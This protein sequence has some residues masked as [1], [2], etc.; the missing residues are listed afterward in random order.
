M[1]LWDTIY[2]ARGMP[3]SRYN[4]DNE[5]IIRK[6]SHTED[7]LNSTKDILAHFIVSLST[8]DQSLLVQE[9]MLSCLKDLEAVKAYIACSIT[10][11]RSMKHISLLHDS[12]LVSL[13]LNNS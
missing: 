4:P 7:F 12:L 1:G 9:I 3:E 6:N 10:N 5:D 2:P 8:Q 11:Y 13:D